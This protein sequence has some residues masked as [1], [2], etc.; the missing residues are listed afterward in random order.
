MKSE[1]SIKITKIFFILLMIVFF[2]SLI[3]RYIF[4]LGAIS[5]L[6]DDM[7]WGLWKGANLFGGVALAAGGF[8][9]TAVV[10]IF[11]LKKYKV[12]VRPVVLTSFL[13][14]L[15][16][17]LALLIDDGRPWNIFMPLIFWNTKSVMWEVALCVASY[18]TVLFLEFLPLVWEK[19]GFKKALKFWSWLTPALVFVGVILSTLH[20]SSLGTLLVIVPQKIHPIWYSPIL[21]ILFFF[22]AVVVGLCA[23]NIIAFIYSNKFPEEKISPLAQRLA[24][25]TG[26][27]FYVYFILKII[28]LYQRGFLKDIFV[29]D[30]ASS[31][32][33]VEFFVLGLIPAT[34]LFF[35]KAV[36]SKKTLF[37]LNL[38]L[39]CGIFLNRINVSVIAFQL[40]SNI[41]YFPHFLEI[42]VS[43][44]I[45]AIAVY[46][47]IVIAKIL[48]VFS[49]ETT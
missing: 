36:N 21:P 11:N 5:N 31:L 12:F 44:S 9:V 41:D 1:P 16:V 39:V 45:F 19:M 33:V 42:V 49:K 23:T 27:V 40:K 6:S 8:V 20:Q 17:I 28:E 2:F 24:K 10:Y 4:G 18:T 38:A 35:K 29:F 26:V 37:G 46:L 15:M 14:Y 13:G 32:F 22:S 3:K 48:P 47:F 7:P 43:F 30:I 25:S 34:A